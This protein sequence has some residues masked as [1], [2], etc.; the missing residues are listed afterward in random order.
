MPRL[1]LVN[2]DLNHELKRTAAMMKGTLQQNVPQLIEY[3]YITCSDEWIL[4]YKY[5]LE[6]SL[7]HWKD[8]RKCTNFTWIYQTRSSFGRCSDT[9]IFIFVSLIWL[10]QSDRWN[11]STVR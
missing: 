1:Q 5:E 4:V 2:S 7:K 3:W 11:V 10:Y 9:D 8:R 6:Y